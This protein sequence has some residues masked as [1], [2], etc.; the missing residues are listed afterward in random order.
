MD[1]MVTRQKPSARAVADCASL[2]AFV[3]LEN[4]AET[5]RAEDAVTRICGAFGYE[6][7]DVLALP[8]G[9]FATLREADGSP[10]TLVRRVKK[11]TTHLERIDEANTVSRALCEGK[12]TLDEASARFY[13][14]SKPGNARR[15]QPLPIAAAALSSGFF[16]AM[17]GGGV[18]EFI[19]AALCGVC[20]QTATQAFKREDHF[21]LLISL[22]GGGVASLVALTLCAVMA[23]GNATAIISGAIMPILPGLAMTNAIRDT[24]RGDLVSGVARGAE[25]VLVAVAIAAGAGVVMGAYLMMG[26]TLL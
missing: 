2:A 19:V 18:F 11:R 15:Q 24:M 6:G 12:L 22:I 26:G 8:T 14:M 23:R 25:A 21:R 17:F 9:V 20:I 13:G 1:A 3:M 10:V 4:G 16:A 5:Y 7:A